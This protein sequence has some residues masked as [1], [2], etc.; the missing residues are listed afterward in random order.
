MKWDYNKMEKSSMQQN[1]IIGLEQTCQE[2]KE[3]HVATH[4]E[5]EKEKQT[6]IA[7]IQD[8]KG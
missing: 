3:Q 7:Q 5:C 6:L 2:L 4:I 1:T 8:W